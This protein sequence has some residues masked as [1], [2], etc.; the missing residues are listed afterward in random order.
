MR[1]PAPRY[2]VLAVWM[3]VSAA[4]PLGRGFAQE[5]APTRQTDT[6]APLRPQ[7]S[8]DKA[9]AEYFAAYRG[10]LPPI[11]PGQIVGVGPLEEPTPLPP[12]RRAAPFLAFTRAVCAADLVVQGSSTLNRVFLN[13]GDTYLVSV[14]DV[15]V[16]R[17]LR[18]S[19][20][21]GRKVEVAFAGGTASIAA[22][23]TQVL[24]TIPLP[25]NSLAVFFLKRLEKTATYVLSS[26]L[27]LVSVDHDYIVPRNP[28]G[29]EYFRDRVTE[30]NFLTD[31]GNASASCAK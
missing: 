13:S 12:D 11:L 9:L 16:V 21:G 6:L 29:L 25:M 18:P 28:T 17:Q 8:G 31:V 30:S 1:V 26:P 20:S 22:V 5:A 10:G 15:S 2:I 27:A 23:K 3:S 4:T 7:T 14:L 19:T 24:P